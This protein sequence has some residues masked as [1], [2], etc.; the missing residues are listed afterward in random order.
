MKKFRS[1]IL[2]KVFLVITF[3]S[4]F[5][6]NVNVSYFG[7]DFSYLKWTKLNTFDYVQQVVQHYFNVNGRTI[8]HIL[9]SIFLGISPV[10]WS[11][12]NSLMLVGICYFAAKIITKKDKERVPLV[13]SIMFFF[14][15]ALDILVTRQSVYWMTGSFNYVYP[16][17]M[18]FIYWYYLLK[19][20]ESKKNFIYAI[21]F[22]VLASAS[23]EQ[24]GMMT[25]GI[26]VLTLLSKI[27]SIK[28]VMRKD[29]L[30]NL[31]IENKR[32]CWLLIITFCG[33]ATVILAPGQ[34]VRLNNDVQYS[35]LRIIVL[36]F[37]WILENFT[38]GDRALIYAIVINLIVILYNVN[39]GNDKKIFWTVA[40]NLISI[41]SINLSGIF[42][43][44]VWKLIL[45]MLIILTYVYEIFFLNSKIEN[46]FFSIFINAVVLMVGSQFMMII[47]NVVGERNLLPGYIMYS[48]IISYLIV[49]AKLP[50]YIDEKI[51]TICLI[52][53]G[54]LFNARTAIGYYNSKVIWDKNMEIIAQHK[55]ESVITLRRFKDT[56]YSWSALYE[57][58]DHTK[59]F[60]QL[61]DITA[62]F[63]WTD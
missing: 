48:F 55:T 32:L 15:A 3:L 35:R 2:E 60:K 30:R 43:L 22:G 46:K 31:I 19:V 6:I 17:C 54:I 26:T 52:F 21:I 50:K 53:I 39:C 24:M 16:I 59:Y 10:F 57:S 44:S 40:V 38:T 36:N 42:S 61:Y 47:S 49:N 41:V 34:F 7:D 25:F 8:V 62:E 14:I 13:F 51:L 28:Y 29:G 1:D 23:V 45:M 58:E 5:M 11:I 18:F 9:D 33:L 20:D 37:R 4:F 56:N 63:V 12:F 27:K